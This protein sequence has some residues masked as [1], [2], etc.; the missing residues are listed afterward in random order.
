MLVIRQRV[1]FGVSRVI[2]MRPSKKK[3]KSNKFFKGNVQSK[4][5]AFV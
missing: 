5:H 4:K 2:K 1:D 3:K